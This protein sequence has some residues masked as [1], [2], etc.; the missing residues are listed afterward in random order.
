LAS[1]VTRQNPHRFEPLGFVPS[2]ARPAQPI[3]P[4]EPILIGESRHAT[5]SPP[6]RTP[7]VRAE[8]SETGAQPIL[9][10]E[11]ILIGE[12]RHATNPSLTFPGLYFLRPPGIAVLN[13]QQGLDFTVCVGGAKTLFH[14]NQRQRRGILSAWVEGPGLNRIRRFRAVGPAYRRCRPFPYMPGLQPL[15]P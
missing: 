11:P 8:R 12:S 9:P 3:L 6:I 10:Q 13:D 2:A 1:R 7:R 5:K 4:Q 14:S 15:M